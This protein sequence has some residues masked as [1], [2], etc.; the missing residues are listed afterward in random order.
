[1]TRS[2]NLSTLSAV[3]SRVPQSAGRTDTWRNMRLEML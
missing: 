1:V 2:Q 3:L